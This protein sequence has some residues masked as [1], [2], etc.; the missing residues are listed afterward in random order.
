MP[1][2]KHTDIKKTLKGYQRS[3]QKDGKPIPVKFRTLV[4][5]LKKPERYT[6]LIHSYPAK[7]LAN[8]PYF[9]FATDTLCPFDGI[10]LDP[11][12]GT[13][14]VLLEA[15]LSG[16]TAWGA[17]SNPL[18][19]TEKGNP[20]GS[21]FLCL[22]ALPSASKKSEPFD[23]REVQ[24]V[25]GEAVDGGVEEL[26]AEEFA[27][28]AIQEREAGLA[29]VTGAAVKGDGPLLVISVVPAAP[30]DLHVAVDLLILLDEFLVLENHS[31]DKS[32]CARVVDP[33]DQDEFREH[34]GGIN[35]AGCGRHPCSAS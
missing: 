32:T 20:T 12:C 25:A 2:K 27:W 26:V 13:G 35:R 28:N 8:I 31:I 10:V 1:R 34:G 19:S 4:P 11:F 30:M 33:G 9:F 24:F 29:V 21:L 14:T 16:R 5:E 23:V 6:H 18:T 7:L 15:V 3:F 17:D 22:S